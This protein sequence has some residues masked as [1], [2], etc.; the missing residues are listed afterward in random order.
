MN[1]NTELTIYGDLMSQPVRSVLLF[2]KLN[3]IKYIFQQVL[4]SKGEQYSSDYKNIN[5][6]SKVPAI[7]LTHNGKD[8]ILKES[9]SILKFLSEYYKVDDKYYPSDI[10]RRA[11]INEY[12]DWHHLNTRYIL[13]GAV[14]KR[15]LEP[16]LL[17]Q[18][19]KINSPDTF[20]KIPKILKYLDNLLSKHKYIVDDEISIA[21]LIVSCEVNQIAI[22]DIDINQYKHLNEYM[23]KINCLP[24]MKEV[25]VILEKYMKKLKLNNSF[26]KF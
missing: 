25:N 19:F 12:L 10:F 6:I 11:L 9:I 3:K 24:E 1:N 18:G 22:I 5:P 23:N 2:C 14:Y 13:S 16:L 26:A 21:D 4:L 15:L 20:D 7:K 8:F 17:K